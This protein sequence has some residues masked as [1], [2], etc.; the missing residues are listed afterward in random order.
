MV[1][2]RRAPTLPATGNCRWR[3]KGRF[4]GACR[5]VGGSPTQPQAGLLCSANLHDNR[6][7]SIDWGSLG[8]GGDSDRAEIDGGREQTGEGWLRPRTGSVPLGEQNHGTCAAPDRQL[9]APT[10]LLW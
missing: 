4:G 8:G 2:A 10:R 7:A 6:T 9:T 5:C 3:E 1:T